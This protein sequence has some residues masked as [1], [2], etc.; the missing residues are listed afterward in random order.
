MDCIRTHFVSA[1]SAALWA[2]VVQP[3]SRRS[4]VGSFRGHR[5]TPPP[6]RGMQVSSLTGLVSPGRIAAI[7]RGHEIGFAFRFQF[8]HAHIHT[9]RGVGMDAEEGLLV[10][11]LDRDHQDRPFDAERCIGR[12]VD[13]QRRRIEWIMRRRF[14]MPCDFPAAASASP[15]GGAPLG[16]AD[17]ALDVPASCCADC[18]VWDAAIGFPFIV[19]DHSVDVV[20]DLAADDRGGGG[21]VSGSST[22]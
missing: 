10:R 13:A 17:L 12:A 22:W 7:A 5:K 21:C 14:A 20:D 15:S 16:L 9:H 1:I 4:S 18:E 6:T 2:D 3:F 19:G 8:D 11:L